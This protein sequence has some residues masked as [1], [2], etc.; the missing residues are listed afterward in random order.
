[1][2]DSKGK[3]VLYFFGLSSYDSYVRLIMK[4]ILIDVLLVGAAVLAGILLFVAS[5]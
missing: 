1:V 2:I 5:L 4:T 3:K